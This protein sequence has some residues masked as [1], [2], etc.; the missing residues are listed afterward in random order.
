MGFRERQDERK[1]ADVSTGLH[2]FSW[3][4]GT[5]PLLHSGFTEPCLRDENKSQLAVQIYFS[6]GRYWARIQDR[7]IQEQA[8]WDAGT[9]V[10]FF[11]RLDGALRGDDL[12]WK[13]MR[14]SG[15]WNGNR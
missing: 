12:I 3:E 13:P 1:A 7:E 15:N 4:E 8:F 6:D 10:A 14:Q 5:V 2:D 9:L 11:E